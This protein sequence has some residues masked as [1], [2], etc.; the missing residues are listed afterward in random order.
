[1]KRV[2]ILFMCVALAGCATTKNGVGTRA[3]HDA[4]LNELR[5]AL[6]ANQISMEK[7]LELKNEAD[8]IR[9]EYTSQRSRD[10]YISHHFYRPHI[11]FGFGYHPYCGSYCR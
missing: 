2:L 11:G 1:M 7:Y 4:R 9:L 6:T 3:W 8:R 5:E 10:M